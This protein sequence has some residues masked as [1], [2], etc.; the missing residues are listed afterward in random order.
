[1]RKTILITGATAGI[2]KAAAH[3]FAREGYNIIATGRRAD[4]LAELK[5]EI[6]T[7]NDIA[8]T[9]L[10]FDVQ[11]R[12]AVE[13][14]IKDLKPM[15]QSLDVLLN[16]AGLALGKDLFGDGDLDD[17][18]TM[19]DTNVKGILYMTKACLPLLE[20][21]SSPQ[22]INIGSTAGQEVYELGNIYCATKHAVVAISKAMRIDLLQ[23]GIKVTCINPGAAETEFSLVRF[24]GNREI[25]KTTYD[26]FTPLRPEDV[27]EVIYYTAS[28]PVHVC[29]NDLT[30]TATQQANSFYVNRSGKLFE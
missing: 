26:G 30:I 19:I 2:G 4:K 16:N 20:K 14:A 1:M 11:D 21:S 12:T 9:T 10:C 8:V 15:L 29:I 23:K 28:L 3:K 18:D 17:W 6:T 24:K 5:E 7:A 25:A 13:N 27:A 22:I